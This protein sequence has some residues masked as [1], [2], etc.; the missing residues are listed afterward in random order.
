MTYQEALDIKSKYGQTVQR[1]NLIFFVLVVPSN[2]DDL[3]R[4]LCD[5]NEDTYTDET[6]KQYSSD[7]EFNPYVHI[8]KRLSNLL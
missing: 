4:F 2:T 5:Y 8:S 7:N 1:D 3:F 6:C